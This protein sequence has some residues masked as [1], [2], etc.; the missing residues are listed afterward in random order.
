MKSFLFFGSQ[1]SRHVA[2][3]TL[4]AQ[5]LVKQP[6]KKPAKKI[7]RSRAI[8]SVLLLG[9]L[10]L[11]GCTLDQPATDD[12]VLPTTSFPAGAPKLRLTKQTTVAIG[13]IAGEEGDKKVTISGTVTKRV[14]I[15]GGWLYQVSDDSGSLW[16]LT[17]TSNP[18]VGQIATVE[19]TIRYEAI[20]VGEIDAGD[21]YLAESAYVGSQSDPPSESV[22]A[23]QPVQPVQPDDQPNSANPNASPK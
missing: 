10:L 17:T 13:S 20:A 14:A 19:G 16:V 5:G 6:A 23:P 18:T 1:H 15:L 7:E 21:V 22:V 11:G 2:I 8:V 12:A 3:E 4:L 9:G